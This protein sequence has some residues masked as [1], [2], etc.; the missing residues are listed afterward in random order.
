MEHHLRTDVGVS[1]DCLSLLVCRVFIRSLLWM[2]HMHTVTFCVNLAAYKPHIAVLKKADCE[3][4]LSSCV[5]CFGIEERSR[6]PRKIQKRQICWHALS[7]LSFWWSE[8][9]QPWKGSCIITIKHFQYNWHKWAFDGNYSLH[10]NPHIK[11]FGHWIKGIYY[12]I[13]RWNL[14]Y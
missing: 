11:H 9:C 8:C 4:W 12:L 5:G 13:D 1:P 7:Q 10:M 6:Q 2:S 14:F 3:N